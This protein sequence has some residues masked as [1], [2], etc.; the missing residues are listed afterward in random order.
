MSARFANAVYTAIAKL[1]GLQK[2]E[3][4]NEVRTRKPALRMKIK[5][6]YRA[7]NQV[8]LVFPFRN[9]RYVNRNEEKIAPER[10]PV[11]LYVNSRKPISLKKSVFPDGNQAFLVRTSTAIYHAEYDAPPRKEIAASPRGS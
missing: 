3:R 5:R 10:Y 11:E 9:M 7:K 2:E 4:K 1:E 6:K 8:C